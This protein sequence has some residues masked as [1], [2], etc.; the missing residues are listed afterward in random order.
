MQ[1]SM[2][3][4]LPSSWSN[5]FFLWLVL[6]LGLIIH[7]ATGSAERHA[8]I[9]SVSQERLQDLRI[10]QFYRAGLRVRSP[11]L[12]ISFVVPKDWR[13]RL[14]AGAGVIHMDSAR[15]PGI[16]VIH[17]LE[18]VTRED[19]ATRL[20]EPQ[21]FEEAYVLDPTTPVTIQGKQLSSTYLH[22]DQMGQ[23]LGLLGPGSQAV[24]YLLAG[25]VT[26]R[27]TF[28]EVLNH[29]GAST[30]FLDPE[31]ADLLKTWYHRLNDHQL[32]GLESSPSTKDHQWHLCGTGR[33]VHH[34]HPTSPEEQQVAGDGF[35]EAGPWH[36]EIQ[37]RKVLLVVTPDHALPRTWTVRMAENRI[38]LND[39]PFSLE[40][41]QFVFE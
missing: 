18:N 16:G 25:P 1:Q 28:E 26:E 29:L 35:E 20:R 19:V 41:S 38:A 37:D 23:A 14:A 12:G 2:E 4:P 40:R 32:T 39:Q 9:L 30:R 3:Q 17:L 6:S 21:S 10:G 33:F 24:V 27:K 31:Q 5:S 22:G 36:I 11:Q 8:S 13:V 34:F 15:K 7:N